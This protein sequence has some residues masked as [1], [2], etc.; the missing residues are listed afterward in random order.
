M[1]NFLFECWFLGKTYANN[2]LILLSKW[3]QLDFRMESKFGF[4]SHIVSR[5][6][7]F[8]IWDCSWWFPA[9]HSSR[10][11]HIRSMHIII[12][13]KK[14]KSRDISQILA[15]KKIKG[16]ITNISPEAKYS[17][18]KTHSLG[19]FDPEACVFFFWKIQTQI[20]I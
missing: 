4:L 16:Y 13:F 9:E 5:L 10:S 15:Q 7:N 6:S 14:K 11:M 18:W 17:Q 1:H 2:L 3:M 19:L 12:N 8:S 20:S